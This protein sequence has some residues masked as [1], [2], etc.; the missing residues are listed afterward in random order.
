MEVHT[1]L[2][3]KQ[4]TQIKTLISNTPILEGYSCPKGVVPFKNVFSFHRSAFISPPSNLT[5]WNTPRLFGQQRNLGLFS[6]MQ[7]GYTFFWGSRSFLHNFKV[8]LWPSTHNPTA[9]NIADTA[10][11]CAPPLC[12]Q[13]L[14]YRHCHVLCSLPLPS[15]TGLQTPSWSSSLLYFVTAFT[16]N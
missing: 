5:D 1:C 9:K 4:D 15:G 2:P 7:S 14:V 3:K 10:M 11:F 6:V 8:L 12:L 13:V 16:A